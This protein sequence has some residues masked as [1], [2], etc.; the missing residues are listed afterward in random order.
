LTAAALLPM[1]VALSF[2]VPTVRGQGLGTTAIVLV[3]VVVVLSAGMATPRLRMHRSRQGRLGAA[4]AVY[5]VAGVAAAVAAY[6]GPWQPV[7]QQ[8][9]VLALLLLVAVPF[10]AMAL[11]IA[12]G[13]GTANLAIVVDMTA[14]EQEKLRRE[15]ASDSER[16][17][18]RRQL[19]TLTHG[20]LR[21]R[22][23]VCAMALNFHAAEI[24]TC[25]PARTA[26][27]TTSVLDHLADAVSELDSLR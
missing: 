3:V 8:N 1:I 22:L 23:A 13:L 16:L 14:L 12:V 27:I 7:S 6:F 10:A 18:V 5:G 20:P 25:S 11:S 26:F 21:G 19:E 24:E 2:E 17:A 4:L 15:T 9:E